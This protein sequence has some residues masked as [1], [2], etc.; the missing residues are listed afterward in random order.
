MDNLT[1]R[2]LKLVCESSDGL[3][4]FQ[5]HRRMY[6]P[7][8]ELAAKLE[9]MQKNELINVA[10]YSV[11]VTSKGLEAALSTSINVRRDPADAPWLAI[12]STFK[13]N[14]IEIN[15]PYAPSL[16]GFLGTKKAKR[17]GIES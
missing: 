10:G 8:T 7:P 16:S 1:R 14:K 3:Q 9:E 13:S 11:K 17:K 6:I 5:L 12:P 4:F 2:L 15:Q